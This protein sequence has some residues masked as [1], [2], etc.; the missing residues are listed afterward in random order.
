MQLN[1][2]IHCD[3]SRVNASSH[4]G[5][6][7]PSENSHAVAWN[8]CLE[9]QERKGDTTLLR[10][11]PHRQKAVVVAYVVFHVAGRPVAGNSVDCVKVALDIPLFV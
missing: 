11:T 1:L 6:C 2:Q 8:C 9:R 5:D 4:Y 7:C 10:E 3:N